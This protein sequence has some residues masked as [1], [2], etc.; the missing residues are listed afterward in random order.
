VFYNILALIIIS[1][2]CSAIIHVAIIAMISIISASRLII[3]A[4]VTV[5]CVL[6]MTDL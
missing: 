1:S 5:A 3:I 2:H 6:S 4:T